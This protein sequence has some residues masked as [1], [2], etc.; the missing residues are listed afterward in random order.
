MHRN[1]GLILLD[2]ANATAEGDAEIRIALQLFVDDPRELELLG[3]QPKGMTG[4]VGDSG[5]IECRN[6]AVLF[7]AILEA[8]RYQTLRD[9]IG[10]NPKVVKDIERRRMKGGRPQFFAKRLRCLE[11]RHWNLTAHQFGRR[12]QSD[13]PGAGDENPIACVHANAASCKNETKYAHWR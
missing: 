3:L 1:T 13:G 10:R 9:Q 8:R 6:H 11:H 4:H 5:E 2:A 12:N 7:R